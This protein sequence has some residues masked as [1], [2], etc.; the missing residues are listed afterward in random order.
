MDLPIKISTREE[1]EYVLSR[2][3]NPLLDWRKF[4]IPNSLRVDIQRELFGKSFISK[5]SNLVEAN[6]RF[7]RYMWENKNHICEECGKPLSHYSSVFIS[8]ILSRGAKPE[9]AHDPRNINILC[10]HDHNKWE[11]ETTR[12]DMK[13]YKT[14]L[15]IIEFLKDDYK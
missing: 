10:F 1:F 5:G 8:H 11:Q 12:K 15:I 2:D 9:M 13:I 7:Y 6:N 14:N 4:K 3:Y